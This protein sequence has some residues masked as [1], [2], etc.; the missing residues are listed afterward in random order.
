MRPGTIGARP[1]DLEAGVVP[2]EPVYAGIR[3]PLGLPGL[4]RGQLVDVSGWQHY[5]LQF[6]QGSTCR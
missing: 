2:I 4:A 3:W 6:Q 5:R 1:G